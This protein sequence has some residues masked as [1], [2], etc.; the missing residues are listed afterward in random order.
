MISC[1]EF[2]LAYSELFTFLHER[3]GKSAVI[4]LW[5]EIADKFLD[6]LRELVR[7]KG[8]EGMHEYWSRTLGEEGGEYSLLLADDEF[9]IEMKA[10]PSVATLRKN[11]HIE[12][13][14]EYCQHCSVLYRRVIE[15]YGYKCNVA[16]H[17]PQAGKCTLTVKPV[18]EP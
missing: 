15:P 12:P 4:C 13:Y 1:T 18:S 3:H 14:P 11:E 5:E 8:L 2:V 7:L 9:R 10:C 17:D 16:V 6:D